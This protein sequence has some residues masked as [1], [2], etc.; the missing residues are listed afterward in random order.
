[1]KKVGWKGF[2]AKTT[3]DQRGAVNPFMIGTIVFAIL[4]IGA[5]GAFVWAFM[6]MQDYRNNVDKKVAAAVEVAKA[7]QKKELQAQFDEDY[8]RPN[9]TFQSAS[10]FGS[11]TFD[12]PRTWAQ[13]IAKNTD[14]LEVYF[15]PV[16]VPTVNSTTP[17]ALRVTVTTRAYDQVLKSYDSKVKD[18]TLRATTLT[19]GKTDTFAGFE[20]MRIDGQFAP[21]INGSTVIFKIRDKTLQIFVD[22]KDFMKDF[23]G[24]VLP[25]LHFEP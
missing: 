7:D 5:A 4:A 17:F 22:S 2:L 9:L 20:G 11:V 23:D 21:T 19:I 13:Y 25:S 8:K 12:Y 14:S 16:A 18:G 15:N 10:V 3:S 24:T 1:M 6:Q